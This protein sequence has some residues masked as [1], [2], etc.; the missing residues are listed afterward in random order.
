MV[1][2]VKEITRVKELHKPY[3]LQQYDSGMWCGVQHKKIDEM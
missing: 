1:N 2:R 3:E